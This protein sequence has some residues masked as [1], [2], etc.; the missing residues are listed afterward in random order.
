M[1]TTVTP[2]SNLTALIIDDM[3][4]QQTTLRGHLALL[5]ISKAD[6]VSNA[7]DAMRNIR[8]KSTA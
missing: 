2:Y 4:V 1:A 6:A 8:A 5:G 7:E 3:A